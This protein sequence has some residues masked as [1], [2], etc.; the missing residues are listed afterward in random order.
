VGAAISPGVLLTRLPRLLFVPEFYVLKFLWPL[1]LTIEYDFEPFRRNRLA[2]LAAAAGL[3]LVLG[4]LVIRGHRERTLG[5]LL[6]WSYAVAVLP[7]TNVFND[8]QIVGDRYAQLPLLWLTPL[9]LLAPARLL[10]GRPAALAAALLATALFAM[11]FRQV[12]VCKY[13]E[14]LYRHALAVHP[15][16]VKALVNLGLDL[17]DAGR[18]QEALALLERVYELHEDLYYYDYHL[19]R[20]ALREGNLPEAEKRLLAAAAKR[21]H[22]RHIVF[23][24][25]G[26]VYDAM[27]DRRRALDAYAQARREYPAFLRHSGD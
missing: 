16:A 7:V 27:G 14:T 20:M 9:I 4:L 19:G 15:R 18:D 5:W 2:V 6:A 1:D 21:G 3:G 13:E 10:P 23:W 11:S 12:G 26:E 22:S 17:S 24:R 8:Y 25:L